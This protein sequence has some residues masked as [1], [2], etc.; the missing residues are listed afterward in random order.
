MIEFN[1]KN[2][3]SEGPFVSRSSRGQRVLP[4]HTQDR[5]RNPQQRCSILGQFEAEVPV[6]RFFLEPII[7]TINYAV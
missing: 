2:Y 1:T 7:L 6:M 4:R 5:S 3:R